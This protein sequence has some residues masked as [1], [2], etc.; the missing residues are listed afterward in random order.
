MTGSLII[1]SSSS[2]P[3]P[4]G[5]ASAGGKQFYAG[6]GP[7]TGKHA[8]AACPADTELASFE[9]QV[10]NDHGW[11]KKLKKGSKKIWLLFEQDEFDA[12]KDLVNNQSM[13]LAYFP[14]L[15]QKPLFFGLISLVSGRW[16]LDVCLQPGRFLLLRC[17]LRRRPDVEDFPVCIC[18]RIHTWRPPGDTRMVDGAVPAHGGCRQTGGKALQKSWG[19]TQVGLSMQPGSIKWVLKQSGSQIRRI[20]IRYH[21]F[22]SLNFFF[23]LST[24]SAQQCHR[25]QA[26]D[27]R[28][29]L[30]LYLNVLF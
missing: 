21:H 25:D 10:R 1:P 13:F 2:G 18:L 16:C 14:K 30:L 26:T 22:F 19:K 12:V 11:K 5:S 3:C 7:V 15:I 17:R 29:A 20:Y 24:S 28:Q 6:V 8:A 9:T 27:G 23:S 4:P